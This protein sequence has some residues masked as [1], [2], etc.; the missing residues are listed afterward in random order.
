MKREYIIWVILISIL[1]L[2]IVPI[3]G[4]WVMGM[5]GRY[6]WYGMM[7]GNWWWSGW[8]QACETSAFVFMVLLMLAII[9]LGIYVIVKLL[10]RPKVLTCE[11]CKKELDGSWNVCPYCGQKVEKK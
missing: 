6:G 3:G 9:V 2:I 1:L 7:G 5:M 8:H 10:K 11:N 4:M